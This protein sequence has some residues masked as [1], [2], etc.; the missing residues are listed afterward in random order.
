MKLCSLGARSVDYRT[1]VTGLRA[2][3]FTAAARDRHQVSDEVQAL[4]QRCRTVS[5]SLFNLT[6]THS[7]FSRRLNSSE[8]RRPTHRSSVQRA[9][10]S[11]P[12]PTFYYGEIYLKLDLKVLR[13][14]RGGVRDPQEDAILTM[15]LYQRASH[16][17]ED[18]VA[19]GSYMYSGANSRNDVGQHMA[20]GPGV[21][22]RRDKRGL[23]RTH[24]S[25]CSNAPLMVTMVPRPNDAVSTGEPFS[26]RH[27]IRATQQHETDGQERCSPRPCPWLNDV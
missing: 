18:M 14:K 17:W 20:R 7:A 19:H 26:N 5:H 2:Q 3:D 4:L 21:F 27:V 25:Q 15:R 8:T 1:S 13:N 12:S 11:C 23:A 9:R 6:L 22:L 16:E 10:R 24:A